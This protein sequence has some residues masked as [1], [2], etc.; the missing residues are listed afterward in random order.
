VL[1]AQ[2]DVQL[3]GDESEGY[4]SGSAIVLFVAEFRNTCRV[5]VGFLRFILDEGFAI[6]RVFECMV[7]GWHATRMRLRIEELE[8]RNRLPRSPK[9]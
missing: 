2:Q 6:A 8:E 3:S 4:N 7:E 9:Q 1:R 5:R